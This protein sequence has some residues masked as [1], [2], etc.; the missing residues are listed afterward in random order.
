VYVA[1]WAAEERDPVG[2]IE[3]WLDEHAQ[4]VT[5]RRFGNVR[6]ALYAVPGKVEE[7]IRYLPGITF[8]RK[9]ELIGYGL[10]ETSVQPGGTIHLTLYWRALAEMGKDYTVFSH[11][12]DEENRIWAQHDSQP[13]GGQRPTSQWVEG[14]V[15]VDEHALILADNVFPG[16]YQLE[17]GM[18]DWA[19]GERLAV[20]ENGQWVP[21]NRVILGTVHLRSRS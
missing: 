5:E 1:F 16:V 17:V 7:G 10:E 15:V 19:S 9:V 20:S 18:Y 2:F 12:I 4:Q 8:E 21:E 3:K 11:L 6:L 13:Q 14:E